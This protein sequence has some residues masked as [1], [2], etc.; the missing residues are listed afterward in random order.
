MGML[1]LNYRLA[2]FALAL[3]SAF[4]RR[5]R[6]SSVRAM[7]GCLNLGFK[8]L[9]LGFKKLI[10]N[11]SAERSK[12]QVRFEICKVSRHNENEQ[13]SMSAKQAVCFR[14]VLVNGRM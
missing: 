13:S 7:N 4:E 14:L 10:E 9:D 1:E 2:L 12:E 11:P 5:L 8:C 6:T 3:P